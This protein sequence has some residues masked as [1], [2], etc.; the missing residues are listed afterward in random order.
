MS[1]YNRAGFSKV[2]YFGRRLFCVERY[3]PSKQALYNKT[4][5]P[6]L[7]KQSRQPR[8]WVEC[9]QRVQARALALLLVLLLLL[10]LQVT[11]ST[12]RSLTV[13]LFFLFVYS[14]YTLLILPCSRW[15]SPCYQV[16]SSLWCPK[17]CL[18]R[19]YSLCHSLV[20]VPYCLRC[21]RQ[22]PQC[23]FLDWYQG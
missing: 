16:H 22:A 18:Q 8:N 5:T 19:R 15:W 1:G 9:F 3:Q 17:H 4:Y 23:C 14:I 10:V 2:T 21:S 11:A 7:S 12:H 6:W 13:R 20:R